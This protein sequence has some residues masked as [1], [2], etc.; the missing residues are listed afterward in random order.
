MT[1]SQ[2][3]HRTA[4]YA[5]EAQEIG[6]QAAKS[7]QTMG[8]VNAGIRTRDK[9]LASPPPRSGDEVCLPY[10]TLLLSNKF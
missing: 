6:K 4:F 5:K 2:F 7:G 10:G 9:A 3:Y 8:H 1:W